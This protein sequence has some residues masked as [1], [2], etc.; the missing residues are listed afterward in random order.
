MK[1]ISYYNETMHHKVIH[2]YNEIHD[3]LYAYP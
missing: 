2:T 3:L 1:Y